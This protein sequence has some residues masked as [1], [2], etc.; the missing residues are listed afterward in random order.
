MNADPSA[1]QHPVGWPKW[2][3]NTTGLMI[4]YTVICRRQGWVVCNKDCPGCRG[5]KREPIPFT[6]FEAMQRP[7]Q[8][9]EQ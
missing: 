2:Y 3:D 8:E 1:N 6:E 9:D 7:D 5:T 4:P